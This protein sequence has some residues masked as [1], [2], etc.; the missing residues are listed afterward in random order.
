MLEVN[1][2][3]YSFSRFKYVNLTASLGLGIIFEMKGESK[4]NPYIRIPL[5]L[6]FP[7]ERFEPSISVFGFATE[8]NDFDFVLPTISLKYKY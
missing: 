4:I 3:E 1:P 7:I 8:N 6:S 5:K 2:L